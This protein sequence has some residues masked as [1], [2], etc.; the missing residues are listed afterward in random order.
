MA[1]L[2]PKVTE[3]RETL[4]SMTPFRQWL[5]SVDDEFRFGLIEAKRIEQDGLVSYTR[6]RPECEGTPLAYF[7]E[8][9]GLNKPMSDSTHCYWWDG[10]QAYSLM[11]PDW[12]R[13]FHKAV[14]ASPSGKFAKEAL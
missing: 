8:E 12:A 6:H 5:A 13:R 3:M 10:T 11:L 2:S 4:K 9:N 7:L 14:G 1:D